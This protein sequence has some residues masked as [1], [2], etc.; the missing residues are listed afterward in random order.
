MILIPG[1]PG[2]SPVSMLTYACRAGGYT[3]A[4]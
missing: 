4:P 1:I 3:C 2:E